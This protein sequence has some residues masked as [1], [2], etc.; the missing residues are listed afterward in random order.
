MKKMIYVT[1]LIYIFVFGCEESY[2]P[3]YNT[4]SLIPY[5]CQPDYYS[6]PNLS[7]TSDS[8]DYEE[9]YNNEMLRHYEILLEQWEQQ[10]ILENIQDEIRRMRYEMTGGYDQY[11]GFWSPYFP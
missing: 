8:F 11:T 6:S 2:T 4:S 10:R 7:I 9:S 1:L 5:W 3:V